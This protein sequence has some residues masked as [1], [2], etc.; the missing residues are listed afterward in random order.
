MIRFSKANS[1]LRK[2][3][4]DPELQE[5]LADGK[6]IYSFNLT[7]GHTCPLAK[8]CR[9]S[10]DHVTRKVVDGEDTEFRCFMA[11][12]EAVF[13]SVH[14]MYWEN[15]QSVKRFKS[16][17][18]LAA[19]LDKA[20]PDNAGIVRFH[21]GGDFFSELYFKAMILLAAKNPDT[22]YYFYTKMTPFL[23]KWRDHLNLPNIVWTASCGGKRDDLIADNN[24]R[25]AIVV[26]S[27]EE[28]DELGLEID[29]DDTHAAKPSYRKHDFA[30]LIHGVQPEGSEAAKALQLLK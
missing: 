6:K 5:W 26:Y 9:S 24:L 30:L 18:T 29:Y 12:L 7:S 8:E 3:A 16:P 28:A 27:E 21:T 4:K 17:A 13:P 10:V 1:K 2:L 20:Q 19:G 11:S 15:W 25:A 14:D 22:L 23:V